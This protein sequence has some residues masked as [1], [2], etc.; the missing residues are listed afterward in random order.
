[1]KNLN[2]QTLTNLAA[3][4]IFASVFVSCTDSRR[5]HTRPTPED[6]K[7]RQEQADKQAAAAEKAFI[8]SKKD[9]LYKAYGYY[10]ATSSEK[11][12]SEFFKSW[13]RHYENYTQKDKL[14]DE[15]YKKVEQIS[16]IYIKKIENLER[17]YYF[18]SGIYQN[19]MEYLLIHGFEPGLNFPDD[20]SQEKQ[21]A[22]KKS[23]DKLLS[24]ARQEFA[25]FVEIQKQKYAKYY[26][27]I[28]AGTNK[29]GEGSSYFYCGKYEVTHR[30]T[31]VEKTD[32][33]PTFFEDRDAKYTLIQLGNNQWQVE[34]NKNGI[35][36]KNPV[37]NAKA[38]ITTEIYHS[39]TLVESQNN[40]WTDRFHSSV[41]MEAHKI[42]VSK[43]PVI[44]N[45]RV[46]KSQ[47]IKSLQDSVRIIDNEIQRRNRLKAK[48]D[49]EV[50]KMAE[51]RRQNLKTR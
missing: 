23:I 4:M 43:K 33:D 15:F 17:T 42:W 35:I 14:T 34:K 40:L 46:D 12:K 37:F 9:S 19:D 27:N 13:I 7:A 11:Y 16:E 24:Q 50:K 29:S 48:A 6:V 8:E 3:L 39:D 30:K 5:R 2:K 38:E 47:D 20:M 41:D 18:S 25:N 45:D 1:M 22:L 51:Y 36:S 49:E 44:E 32:M 26:T 10:P 28:E 31:D 21:Q